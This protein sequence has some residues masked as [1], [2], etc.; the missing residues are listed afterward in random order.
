MSDWIPLPVIISPVLLPFFSG[1]TSCFLHLLTPN[2]P[3][4]LG[5]NE[6]IVLAPYHTYYGTL[7]DHMSQAGLSP[8]P[9]LWNSPICVG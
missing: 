7:E 4:I 1:S 2:R 5:S 6:S 3:V 9:N 8:T